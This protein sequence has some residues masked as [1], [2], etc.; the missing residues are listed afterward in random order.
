MGLAESVKRFATGKP[1]LRKPA[2]AVEIGTDWVKVAESKFSLGGVRLAKLHARRIPPDGNAADILAQVFAASRCRPHGVTVCL[3]RNQVAVR[4]LRVP[5]TD[6]D[7]IS[8]IVHLQAGRQTPYSSDEVVSGYDILGSDQEGYSTVM[9]A[10]ARRRVLAERLDAIAKAGG[11]VDTIAA[12]T[13]GV[14]SRI[15]EQIKGTGNATV[16]RA[17]LNV[18]SSFSEL[19]IFHRGTACLSKSILIGAEA[20]AGDLSR[21]QGELINEIVTGLDQFKQEHPDAENVSKMFIVGIDA[22]PALVSALKQVCSIDLAA[23]ELQ[24]YIPGAASAAFASDAPMASNAAVIGCSLDPETLGI[25]LLPPELRLG[26]VMIRRRNQLNVM[27]LLGLFIVAMLLTLL[28]MGYY[29]RRLRVASLENLVAEFKPVA[30]ETKIRKDRIHEV[31]R[32]LDATGSPIDALAE[33]HAITPG[34]ISL[35]HVGIETRD[36]V[37]IRGRAAAMADVFEFVK[38]LEDSR[39][40]ANVAAPYTKARKLNN[41]EFAEFAIVCKIQ[42]VGAAN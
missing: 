32:H 36:N 2:V 19:L 30:A 7:E 10:I 12:G 21:W 18:D 40:F 14:C 29:E 23:E 26:R 33:L 11:T 39:M 34:K 20:L 6:P 41:D 17:V 8:K 28:V 1:V 22:P 4:M 3:P 27:G 15:P 24:A 38:V 31:H 5:A 9:L 16:P 37:S 42:Q 25:D 35:S 13:E